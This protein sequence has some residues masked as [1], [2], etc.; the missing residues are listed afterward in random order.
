MQAALAAGVLVFLRGTGRVERGIAG[1][2]APFSA[3][4]ARP[5]IAAFVL[6]F[7]GH[8]QYGFFES[9][10]GTLRRRPGRQRPDRGPLL[11]HFAVASL[12][13][14]PLGGRLADRGDYS[15]WLLV[16]FLGLA[17][18]VVGYGR[19]SRRQS[20]WRSVCQGAVAAIAFP[21]LDA[22]LA[23]RADPSIQG[24]IGGVQLRDDGR[25]GVQRP[26]RLL[27]YKLAPGLPFIVGGAV[28]A[29]L[30]IFA[31]SLIRRSEQPIAAGTLRPAPRCNHQSRSLAT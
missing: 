2:R 9:I 20:S 24:R 6:G 30:T 23:S 29:G 31:V 21:T 17:A 26:R 27:L 13:L 11:Q 4:L 19:R 18:V 16:G 22:Y 1:E 28:L 5:L 15:R 12:T 3:L 25:R 7:A 10:W 8:I 14:A